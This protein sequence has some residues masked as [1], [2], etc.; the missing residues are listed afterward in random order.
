MYSTGNLI[1]NNSGW[2]PDPYN[3]T[4]LYSLSGQNIFYEPYIETGIDL[5][6]SFRISINI[7]YLFLNLSN[8]K[9]TLTSTQG[10]P[11]NLSYASDNGTPTP[12]GTINTT[13]PATPVYHQSVLTGFPNPFNTNMG[14]ISISIKIQ[15]SYLFRPAGPNI[16]NSF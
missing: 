2:G 16:I 9:A 12:F 10:N 7:A 11:S 14:G 6:H 1:D 3:V 5:G 15:W 13:V 4:N 8:L